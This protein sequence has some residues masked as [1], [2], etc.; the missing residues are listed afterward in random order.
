MLSTSLATS[1]TTIPKLLSDGSNWIVWKTR[2]ELLLGARKLAHLLDE[3]TVR[4]TTPEPLGDK[5]SATQTADYEAALEKCQEFDRSNLEAKHCIAQTIP[6]FLVI[7]TRNCATA[8][9]LWKTLCAE[10]E[11]KTK[12]FVIEMLRNLQNQRC[13]DTDDVK[14]HLAKLLKLREELATTGKVL[15]NADFTSIIT[16]S[17]PP[18]YDNVVSSAYAAANAIDKEIGTDE[19]ILII[20]EEH[21]R[22]QIS[23]GNSHPTSTALFSNPQKTSSRRNNWKK[24]KDVC[25]NQKCRFRSNHEF[26]DC[27][28]EG[29]P[30]YGQ[31]PPQL[32]N[33]SGG[34]R[35]RRGPDGRSARQI[36]RANVAHDTGDKGSNTHWAHGEHIVITVNM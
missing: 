17:L 1:Q 20:R 2:I 23:S 5:P 21:S 28:S 8:G 12:R 18:S 27:R 25:T 35:G 26:K 34:N 19:I 32:R 4:P 30:R 33:Q 36:M 24:K 9:K 29:G 7:E 11:K 22:R 10:H 15:D 3:T 31:T 6:D 14:E 16:N 13:S